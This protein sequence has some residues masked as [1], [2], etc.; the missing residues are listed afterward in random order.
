M[1]NFL[2]EV[3]G[4]QKRGKLNSSEKTA[5]GIQSSAAHTVI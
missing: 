2:H 1:G 5:T 3:K 4:T